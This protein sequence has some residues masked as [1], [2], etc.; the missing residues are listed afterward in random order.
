MI[1]LCIHVLPTEIDHLEQLLI[2]LKKNSLSLYDDHQIKVEVC[3][4][5]NFVD[6]NN[7]YIVRSFFGNKLSILEKLTKSWS[8]DSI[9][10]I[11]ENKEIQGCNDLRRHIIRT[12]DRPYVMYL[13]ADNIFGDKL[14]F[15]MFNIVCNEYAYRKEDS[16]RIFTPQTTRLWDSTW[17]CISNDIFLNDTASHNVYE[18]RD[19]YYTV[20]LLD[21]ERNLKLVNG[22]KFAG[23]GTTIDT[24]LA[25]MIDVP[26]S[27]G[28]YG[29][30]D[31]FIMMGCQ[32]LKDKGYDVRQYVIENEIIIE[33]NKFRDNPY[34]NL[35]HTVD[36]KKEFLAQAESNFQ[37]ELQKL[38]DR[39]SKK[40][41]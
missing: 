37:P 14:L 11:S 25:R 23:W 15:Y 39:Y 13:D 3:L 33:N 8:P 19:P 34:S 2:Q 30:D 4:N 18:N 7:S 29:L 12:T 6:F 26:D 9:F 17:D 27:L 28:S 10:Y 20:N 1:H 31:T 5:L 40:S 32:I 16:Y 21:R 24:R 22:F 41:I 35:L 36:K 38:Y